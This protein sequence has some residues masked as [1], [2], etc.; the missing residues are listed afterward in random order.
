M[1]HTRGV[2]LQA[3]CSIRLKPDATYEAIF[4]TA[5][6]SCYECRTRP[7]FVRKNTIVAPA[8]IVEPMSDCVG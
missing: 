2:R 4:S 3:D 5:D 8:R 1:H 7:S 6:K